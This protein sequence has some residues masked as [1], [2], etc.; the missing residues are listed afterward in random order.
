MNDD[1]MRRLAGLLIDARRAGTT[2]DTVPDDLV[3]ADN[4]EAYTAQAIT[5]AALGG[6]AGY[7]IGARSPEAAP[8]FAALPADK[9]MRNGATLAFGAFARVG[10]ELEIAFRFGSVVD[11]S[12]ASLDDTAILSRIAT[13]HVTSEVVDSRY[14]DF[15]KTPKLAQLA[16][17]QNNGALVVNEGV[18]YRDDLPYLEPTVAFRCGAHEIFKGP[19]RNPCGD[20]RRLV[21]WLVRDLL[22][23]GR[24]IAAGDVLTCGSYTG[25]QFV[26]AGGAVSGTID[27]IGEVNYTLA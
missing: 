8:Q 20:P 5:I 2:L 1:R 18:P 7:K 6:S 4:D 26:Q 15:P 27:G 9:V 16:D 13:V 22:A 10:L 14:A 21:T 11:A 17:L 12:F 3:P 23:R 25:C 24:T 19:A